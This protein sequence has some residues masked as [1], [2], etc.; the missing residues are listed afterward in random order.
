MTGKCLA[1]CAK[2]GRRRR[3][4]KN[5]SWKGASALGA[6][7]S[8][9]VA[10]LIEIFSTAYLDLIGQTIIPQLEGILQLFNSDV[11][12]FV[13]AADNITAIRLTWARGKELWSVAAD[14]FQVMDQRLT[15]LN[16]KLDH[17][18]EDFG[19]RLESRHILTE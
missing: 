7:V 1:A 2:S 13:W 10:F 11:Q 19:I 16:L 4:F 14:R 9:R 5:Q 15:D 12:E 17:S 3:M 18:P 6:D 8:K